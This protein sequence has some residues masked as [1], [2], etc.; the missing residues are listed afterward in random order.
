MRR[1]LIAGNWKMNTNLASA[2]ALAKGVV[3]AA[4][5]KLA[6]V[7]VMVAPP[8]P[9]L[10]AVRDVV[11]GTGVALGAQNA[12]E[13]APGAFTGEVALDMLLDTGCSSVILG[14]SERRTLYGE[15]DAVVNKK[16]HAALAKGL[17]VVLCVG[18]LLE[19][20]KAEK[21]NQVLDTQMSGS[22]T[23][24]TAEQL[25]NV[26]IAYEPVWAIGTGL[27]A[28]PEQAQA[29]HAH[30]RNWLAARYNAA[31]AAATRIL[32]G[33]SVKPDN[34][35]ELLSQPDVDGALVGGASL[36]PE[37]FVPII[38]AAVAVAG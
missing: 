30:L 24:V 25:A 29:A 32:Y 10:L 8:S 21:T 33:G 7:D 12:S 2:T 20:R 3:A 26:V 17:Q 11:K 38:E 15:S 27:T 22:L 19:E 36:K 4:P 6:K 16:V 14:H 23:G 35:R 18:E 1:Y 13:Q 5:Q 37:Q 9:Y 31:S 28:T 34:A